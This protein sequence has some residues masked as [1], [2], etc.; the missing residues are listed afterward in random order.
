MN[1]FV[2]WALGRLPP[3]LTPQG[4]ESWAVWVLG[5]SLGAGRGRSPARHALSGL[6]VDPA[7]ARSTQCSVCCWGL[8]KAPHGGKQKS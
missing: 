5:L 1:G 7:V 8:L 6:L 2:L 3:A 4:Q